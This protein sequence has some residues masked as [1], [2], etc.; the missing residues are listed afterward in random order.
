[1][2]YR[3][4]GRSGLMVSPLVL[5]TMNFGHPTDKDES[6]RI[7]HAALE[8]GINLI[9]S[10]NVYAGGESERIVGEVLRDRR[11]EVFITTKVFNRTGPGPNDAG[12]SRHNIITAC[13]ASL[14]RLGTD[15][16]DIYFLHRTDPNVPQEETLA[17]LDLLV[18]QG[19]VRYIAASTHPAWRTVEALHIA[20][21]FGYP[22]FVCEQPPYNLLD[23]RVENEIVPMCQAYDLGIVAWSPLAHG[24]L[25]GR[26]TDASAMPEGT[27][28]TLRE[29]FAERIT[30]AG[31][32]V[33][34]KF[35]EYAK[36]KGVTPAQLA[37]AWVLHQ[38]GVTSSIIGPRT[39]EHLTSV[40]PAAD[41]ALDE[42]DFAVCDALVP[43]GM[44]VTS[45]FNTSRWMP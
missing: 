9:D 35:A 30:Q 6:A 7:I 8:A 34:I 5:G 19:K 12:N 22:K 16:I 4:L 38:P 23:R 41:L 10:A 39:L 18:Q 24:V 42:A 44:V 2:E 26:Y 3:R 31:V 27:R 11:H 20:D 45:F 43:P 33:G 25:A 32:D 37:T 13:E 28:G 21:K 40:L 17:A 14:K 36:G 29:V 15:Y 1:M